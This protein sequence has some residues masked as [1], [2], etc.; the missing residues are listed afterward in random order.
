MVNLTS[1]ERVYS[2]VEFDKNA[3]SPTGTYLFEWKELM[4]NINYYWGYF[5]K[6][7]ISNYAGYN[8]KIFKIRDTHYE[9]KLKT[10]F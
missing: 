8:I 1:G 4:H 7:A 3:I 10:E 2:Q 6:S 5:K 9:C